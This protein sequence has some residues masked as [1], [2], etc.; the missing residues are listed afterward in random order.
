M[1]IRRAVNDAESSTPQTNVVNF[2]TFT[3][4]P[5][6]PLELRRMVWS[7]S[8]PDPRVIEILSEHD[9]VKGFPT[10]W[11]KR[12]TIRK[13]IHSSLF[14]IKQAYTESRDVIPRNY[15]EIPANAWRLANLPFP[16]T[17]LF[18]YEQDIVY[19][20]SPNALCMF[21]QQP[22]AK[23]IQTMTIIGVECNIL[24][25]LMAFL[26]IEGF[27][28]SLQN[29]SQMPNLKSIILEGRPNGIK[30]QRLSTKAGSTPVS[31]SNIPDKPPNDSCK[32]VLERFGRTVQKHME[33]EHLRDVEILFV[34]PETQ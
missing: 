17:V 19:L 10:L 24:D 14:S 15:D 21:V 32:G 30:R 26:D 23:T 9:I 12:T 28:N 6:L 20:S 3:P 16:S 5:R 8:L 7:R 25:I 2:Q 31:F 11:A 1:L 33:L 22:F 13:D 18:N 4:F 34:Q 27:P 29:L